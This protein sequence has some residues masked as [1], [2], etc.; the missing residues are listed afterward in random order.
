MP[1]INGW[2]GGNPPI[3]GNLHM[4]PMGRLI[5]PTKWRPKQRL[6][7]F[8]K[9]DPLKF[10]LQSLSPSVVS[11]AVPSLFPPVAEI[12]DRRPAVF[13]CFWASET[14]DPID[15]ENPNPYTMKPLSLYHCAYS[16]P[17][18]NFSAPCLLCARSE[19]VHIYTTCCTVMSHDPFTSAY[20]G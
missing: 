16:Q 19:I 12:P 2:F 20:N 5:D 15:P 7:R 14:I 6:A 10:P 11:T 4:E 8:W 3:S 1:S 13:H 9:T 18:C 17:F